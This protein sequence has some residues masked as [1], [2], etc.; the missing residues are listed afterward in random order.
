MF[1]VPLWVAALVLAGLAPWV[2]GAAQSWLE[3]RTRRRTEAILR[4][5]GLWKEPDDAKR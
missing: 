5:A 1:P 2:V 3:R 4:D